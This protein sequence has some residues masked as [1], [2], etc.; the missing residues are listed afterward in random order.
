MKHNKH[1]LYQL[2]SVQDNFSTVLDIN[3]TTTHTCFLTSHQIGDKFYLYEKEV[4]IFNGK[5]TFDYS[6]LN[7][8]EEGRSYTFDIV[9]ETDRFIIV[10][11][12]ERLNYAAPI[13]FKTSVNQKEIDLEIYA[14]DLDNNKLKFKNVLQTATEQKT[15]EADLEVFEEGKHYK[16]SLNK[17]FISKNNNLVAVVDYDQK[18]YYISIPNALV[19][20]QLGD[21]LT[22]FLGKFKDGTPTLKLTRNFIIERLYEVGKQYSFIIDRQAIDPE[23]G[24]FYWVLKDTYGMYSHYHPTNDFSFEENFYKLQEG[25]NIELCVKSISI[26]GY[27]NLVCDIR[28]GKGSNYLV[29]DVFE[30]IGYRDREEDCFFSLL[31]NIVK[32]ETELIDAQSISYIEQYNEGENLWVFSYLSFL[33]KEIFNLLDEGGYKK[34]KELIDIYIKIEEWILEGS[35][36]LQNFSTHKIQDIILKAEHKIKKLNALIEAIDLYLNDKDQEFL[37]LLE[38]QLSRSPYLR[39]E[40]LNVFKELVRVSQFFSSDT[41]NQ[42]LYK[43]IVLLIKQGHIIEHDRWHFI[44]TIESNVYS[45]RG[46]VVELLNANNN[47]EINKEDLEILILNQYLLVL[48]YSLAKNELKAS[49]SSVNLLRYLSYSLNDVAYLDLGIELLVKQG[50]LGVEIIRNIDIFNREEC[51]INAFRRGVIFVKD[52]LGHYGGQGYV[53]LRDGGMDLIP[54]NTYKRGGYSSAFNIVSILGGSIQVKSCFSFEEITEDDSITLLFQKMFD[55]LSY[56]KEGELAN[57]KKGNIDEIIFEN[58]RRY[59]GKVKGFNEDQ[60]HYCYLKCKIEEVKIDTL[61]H[62][63]AFHYI[64]AFENIKD[65]LKY[66]DSVVFDIKEIKNSKIIVSSSAI[67][68]EYADNVIDQELETTAIVLKVYGNNCASGITKEGYPIS[69]TDFKCNVGDVLN[70]D[71]VDYNQVK[72][73]FIVDNI[74]CVDIPFRDDP[75]LL[76]RQFL[77]DSGMII[78]KVKVAKKE[79]DIYLNSVEDLSV[80]DATILTRINLLIHCLEQRLVY[81][82][83]Q[84]DVILCYCVLSVISSITKNGKSYFYTNKLNNL[85]HIIKLQYDS[86]L[87]LLDTPEYDN[88]F[89]AGYSELKEESLGFSLLNFYNKELLE[90]PLNI[91]VNSRFFKLKKLIEANNLLGSYGLEAG[92]LSF[93]RNLI[94]KELSDVYFNEHQL[95]NDFEFSLLEGFVEEKK[96]EQ[97]KELTNL[98][99]ESKNKEFKTSLFYSASHES[100]SDIILRSMAGFLNSYDIGGSL[101]I[102]V[103]DNGD[104]KGLQED[105]NFTPNIKTL[106]QYQNYIQSLVVSYFSK[107]VNA[108]IDYYFHKSGKKDYLEIIIPKFDKPISYKNEFYQRQGVQTRILKG[109]DLTDFILRKASHTVIYESLGEVNDRVKDADS[110]DVDI[111]QQKELFERIDFYEDVKESGEIQDKE[112]YEIEEKVL[113]YLYIFDDNTYMISKN[114]LND[115]LFKVEITEQYRFGYLLLCYDNACINKVEIRSILNKTLNKKYMNAMSDYGNL[116]VIYSSLE[117]GEVAIETNRGNTSFIKV[118]D[119]SK[120]SAHKI[121]GLKGNCIVQEDIDKVLRYKYFPELELHKELFPFRRESKQGLGLSPKSNDLS[122]LLY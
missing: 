23:S 44:N 12:Y 45:L 48:L 94:I 63:N 39:E 50:Y 113:A 68:E 87:E 111:V 97:T 37:E 112:V 40:K 96:P 120:I 95:L 10:S 72:M 115:F 54:K 80:Y 27:L 41:D 86:D 121:L 64:K 81:L 75:K 33:D 83:D 49:I 108:L 90:I 119:I 71:I 13:K 6:V 57:E 82:Q 58:N 78:E 99:L 105:L 46:K 20:E 98:G 85:A 93:F 114:N 88:Q 67:L 89:G 43:I 109:S 70:V 101:F 59:V 56:K 51:N 42:L 9:S 110:T 65:I 4:N 24:F 55:M 122:K 84:R 8:Y 79:K 7:L 52:K 107:E 69:I 92:R 91:P 66:G 32:E 118:F 3:N 73:A 61:Y 14:L 47:N 104:I 26:G 17:T 2:L 38:G 31:P 106:D 11:N 100:Q 25:D 35:D 60:N 21:V 116:M 117:K 62:F 53:Q 34:A 1:R 76:F 15:E 18:Q 16:V 36:Y 29:E 102:G 103:S 5:T 28:N 30:A 74:Q 22:V 19:T 77:L